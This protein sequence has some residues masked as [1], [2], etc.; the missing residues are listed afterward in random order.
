MRSRKLAAS[1]YF[2]F[3]S[4]MQL[5][6]I[7]TAS[8]KDSNRS[9]QEIF[10]LSRSTGSH[11]VSQTFLCHR[12]S[13]TTTVASLF[14]KVM[15]R[16]CCSSS[17][18]LS[19]CITAVAVRGGRGKRR[20]DVVVTATMPKNHSAGGGGGRSSFWWPCNFFTCSLRD[21]MPRGPLTCCGS[22]TTEVHSRPGSR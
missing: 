9:D 20:L 14:F 4:L 7:A 1:H 12:F 8:S 10:F 22:L 21:G 5:M 17:S 11:A 19:S 16:T 13:A 15:L 2:P 6:P 18:S 3:Y